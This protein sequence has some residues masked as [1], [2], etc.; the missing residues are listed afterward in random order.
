MLFGRVGFFQAACYRGY[1]LLISPRLCTL[2]WGGGI[3]GKLRHNLL[4]F[5][6]TGFGIL[7][8]DVSINCAKI[9]LS[10]VEI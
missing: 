3:H 8:S 9:T 7:S 10:T 4:L 1:L 6:V 2:F 5:Y